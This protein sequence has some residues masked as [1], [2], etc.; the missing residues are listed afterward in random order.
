MSDQQGLPFPYGTPG[1]SPAAVCSRRTFIKTS[2]CV[3]AGLA[4]LRGSELFGAQPLVITSQATGLIVG[5]PSLCVGCQRCELACTE[6][7]D[8]KADPGLTRI[9]I[10][11]NLKYGPSGIPG[12]DKLGAFG[13]GLVVQDTC[14]QCPHPV[15]C[16]TVCPYGAII[17]EAKSGTRIVD[18]QKCVGCR[19]CQNACPWGMMSFDEERGTAAKCFLCDGVPKCV[20]AC[21]AGALRF[22]PWRNLTK[23]PPRVPLLAP[24]P[25]EQ[26][27]GC[28]VCHT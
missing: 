28:V 21:P 16:A 19:L 9:K 23:T 12:Q 7:N 5:L 6:F 1:L 18:A 8:G 14:R 15:P 10:D 11:R 22:V 13:N 26:A 20:T 3:L 27:A 17:D 25:A 2:G 4:V 24:I